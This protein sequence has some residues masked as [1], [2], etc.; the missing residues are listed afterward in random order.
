MDAIV[1]G[2]QPADPYAATP[3]ITQMLK[4]QLS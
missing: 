4:S 3:Q 1:D 2:A